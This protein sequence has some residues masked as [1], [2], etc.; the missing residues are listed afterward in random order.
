[1]LLPM[2]REVLPE[3]R[4]Y[5]DDVEARYIRARDVSEG[6]IGVFLRTTVAWMDWCGDEIE[7]RCVGT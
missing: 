3:W 1:V 4:P 2:L 7:R 6:E 5:L